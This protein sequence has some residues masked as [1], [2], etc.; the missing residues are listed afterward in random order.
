MTTTLLPPADE[1]KARLNALFRPIAAE[2]AASERVFR[3][4]LASEHAFVQEV[5]DHASGLCGKRLRPAL[6]FLCARASGRVTPD[7]AVLAAVVEMIHVATLIHD[8][9]L[10]DSVIRRHAA[11][12]NAA[13]GNESAVLLGDYLFTHAFHLAATLESTHACR[14]I[15]RATNRVCEGEML[16]VHHRGNLC[17]DEQAYLRII[18]GKTAELLAVSCRLGA[19]YSGA[20]ERVVDSLETYGRELGVAFQIADDVIDLLGE[21]NVSGKTLGT[22]VEKQKLTLPLIRLLST[23][24]PATAND[25]R[26]L[27]RQHDPEA[28]AALRV[29]IEGSDALSYSWEVASRSIAA[30][31][32]ALEAVPPSESR[33]TLAQAARFVVRRPF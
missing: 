25:A 18:R 1:S 22:D 4:A 12:I 32:D 23:S 19:Q 27:I 29:L 10:D 24:S 30:A 21:E 31:L 33:E 20:S 15:G 26:G 8:D 17:L 16:Q 6:L 28:R 14:L 3:E 13:W 5:V 2:L 7:H 9:I 11:T